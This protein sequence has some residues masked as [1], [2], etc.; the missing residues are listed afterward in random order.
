M[1]EKVRPYLYYDSAVT[2][3]P[4][5]YRR[6]EGKVVFQDGKVWMQKWCRVHGHSTVLVADDIDYYRRAR[7]VFL[8]PAEMPQ[9]FNTPM[10]WG[11]CGLCPDHQQHSCLSILELNDACNLDCPICYAGSGRARATEHKP[12]EQVMRMLDCIITN[13]GE[14]DVVQLSGGEPTLHPDFFKI[15][16]ECKKRPIRHLMLNT[17]GVRIASDEAFAE[18]LATY[19]PGFELYLQFDSLRAEALKDLRGEDLTQVRKKALDRLNALN[20]STTLVVTLK[21]GTNLD[22][23]GEILDYA[24]KQRCVRG[25]TFQPIQD[26]GR[27]HNYDAGQHRLTE[28]R[29]AILEQS[30]LF[31]PEDILPVPCH[32]DA[33]AMAYGLKSPSGFAA[34]TGMI[35]PKILIEGRRNTIVYEKDEGVKEAVFKLLSLGHGPEGGFQ[36]L[37]DLLC[38]LPQV[39]LGKGLGYQDLFRVIIMQFHDAHS[40]DVRSVKRSC[41]HIAHPDGKRMIP[42]DTFNLFYRGDLEQTRLEPLRKEAEALA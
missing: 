12:F 26:A 8:K 25:V 41:V 19:Q 38:C 18:K 28:V 34:L 11:D 22:Q 30:P 14:A 32:P 6:A 37:R 21:R 29:R 16:D 10:K 42:F 24:V 9:R 2:L 35:D 1:P 15:L 7:E 20:L 3:C 23:V 27:T 39:A 17:N 13:E 4:Q 5:C 40:F 31:K 36:R 33:L